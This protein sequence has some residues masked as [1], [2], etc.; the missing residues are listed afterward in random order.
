MTAQNFPFLSTLIHELGHGF[1]LTHAV[2]AP[3]S[4]LRQL[5]GV[6]RPLLLQCGK[7]AF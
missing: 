5:L 2:S 7:F 1:G 3:L 4:E 6:N